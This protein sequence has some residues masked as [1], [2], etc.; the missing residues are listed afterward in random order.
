MHLW[1]V[2]FFAKSHDIFTERNVSRKKKWNWP[3]FSTFVFSCLH[4]LWI[5]LFQNERQNG[6]W[7]V[8]EGVNWFFWTCNLIH[9]IFAFWVMSCDLHGQHHRLWTGPWLWAEKYRGRTRGCEQGHG[10]E[11]KSRGRTRGCEQGQGHGL[12][13]TGA[14]SWAEIYRGRGMGCEKGHGHWL[15]STGAESWAVN[16]VMVMAWG[17]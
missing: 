8:L 2:I 5:M 6:M 12:K 17:V 16:R 4:Q 9:T 10:H 15:K 1:G 7:L 13:S 3:I 14:G 11:L